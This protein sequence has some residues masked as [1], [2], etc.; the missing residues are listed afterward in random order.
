MTDILNGKSAL[1]TGASNG[2]GKAIALKLLDAGA[3]VHF[4]ARNGAALADLVQTLGPA[5]SRVT[6]HPVDLS[7]REGIAQLVQG[8]GNPD[9]LVN[10]AG[11]IA[12]GDIEKIDDET[13][14]NAWN[15]KVFGY[16]RLARALLPG[17][18][19][20]GSGVILNVIGMAGL[21]H[22]YNYICG[23]TGNAALIAFTDALGAR[24][25]DK[26]VRVVGINPGGTK[27]ERIE[28]LKRSEA[29]RKLGD[30]ERWR[31]LLT[32]MPF[33]RLLEPKE[34]ANLALFLVSD[35]ASYLSGTEG[36]V[37]P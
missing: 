21:G 18:Y 9:I 10:N 14:L 20:R 13:W 28:R 5:A 7:T 1:V 6:L 33:G 3:H 11:A 16:I 27:T 35:Q 25:T 19:G 37:R 29:E 8:C 32:D 22:D 23:S 12:G 26:G 34:I 4:A 36:S 15:L 2:I 30:P 31:E 17:M 24:S